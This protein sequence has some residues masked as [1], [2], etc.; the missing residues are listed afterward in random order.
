MLKRWM[1]EIGYDIQT[2]MGPNI[3]T[4]IG[5]NIYFTTPLKNE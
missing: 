2:R 5:L 3:R 4:N 1:T